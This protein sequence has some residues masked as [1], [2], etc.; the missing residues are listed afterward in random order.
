MRANTR[1]N[2]R[3]TSTATAALP[4]EIVRLFW[5]TDVATVDL[6]AHRDYV[7]ERIMT[8][9]GWA[10]MRWL[11]AQYTKE[12]LRE[13]LAR[14]GHRIAP[15]ERAYWSLVAG[16]PEVEQATGGGRPPWADQP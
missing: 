15:R 12:E 4:P 7:C 6:A 11:K 3:V 8:R 5:D 13:F 2:P 1:Y 9:G 14:R 16:L 10:A